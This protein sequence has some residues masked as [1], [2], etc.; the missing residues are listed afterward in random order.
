MTKQGRA[1]QALWIA[2]VGSF[3]AGTLSTLGLSII[4]P[5]LAKYAL[6][7][8]PPEKF[9]LIFFSLSTIVSFS[10]ASIAKGLG[11]GLVGI[12]LATVGVDPLWFNRD[13]E[14]I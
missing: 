9:G 3:I 8:G 1:G 7:F 10:G 2:A 4:G 5:G 11:A 13:D 14:G 12:I 6:Q